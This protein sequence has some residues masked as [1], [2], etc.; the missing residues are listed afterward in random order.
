MIELNFFKRTAKMAKD[1]HIKNHIIRINFQ[2]MWCPEII[3]VFNALRYR[4]SQVKCHFFL[5]YFFL[6]FDTP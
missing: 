3:P 6:K 4:Q 5:I 2:R 1:N